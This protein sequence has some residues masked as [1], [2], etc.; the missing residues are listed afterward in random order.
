[1]R[2]IDRRLS[3]IQAR[4]AQQSSETRQSVVDRIRERRRCLRE[5]NGEPYIEP[6]PITLTNDRRTPLSIADT[7]RQARYRLRESGLGRSVT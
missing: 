2:V 4:L 5:A 1:M 3:R 7:I 6:P